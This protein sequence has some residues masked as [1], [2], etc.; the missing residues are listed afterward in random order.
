MEDLYEKLREAMDKMGIGFPEVPDGLAITYLKRYFSEDEAKVYMA[1]ENRFQPVEEVAKRLDRSPEEVKAILDGMAKE[2]TVMT[3]VKISPTFYAP[4]PWLSGWGDYA[5]YYEDAEGAKLEH[6]YRLAFRGKGK[7]YRRNIFRTVPVY[8][9]IPDKSTVAPYDDVRKIVEQ[10]ESIALADCF[11]DLY[12]IRMGAEDKAHKPLERCFSFGLYADFMVERGWGRKVSAKEAIEVLNKCRDTGLIHNVTDT[13]HP[14][15]ICNCGENCGGNITRRVVP[16][17]FPDYEKTNNY[18]A[19]VDPGSCTGCETCVDNCWLKAITMGSEGVVEIKAGG[20]CWVRAVR[21]PV[22]SRG[23]KPQ[24][25]TRV[26][27]IYTR[28]PST[29]T[30]GP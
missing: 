18:I 28:L 22:P 17:P 25:E 8:E 10:A 7:N 19:T 1:M 24:E 29:R 16:G 27:T 14:F 26:G 12:M 13:A 20:M 2:G 6:Q 23:V 4:M 21:G 5:A 30:Q 3:T 11:C 9:A 15:F